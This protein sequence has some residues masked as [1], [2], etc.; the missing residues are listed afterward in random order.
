MIDPN[1]HGSI[2]DL[3]LK[4]CQNVIRTNNT[5]AFRTFKYVRH[6]DRAAYERDGW[7]F[8]AELGPTHGY[9]SVLMEKIEI[10]DDHT[11]KERH[12]AANTRSD[13]RDTPSG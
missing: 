12:G 7:V 11:E 6:E 8:A 10:T 1:R 4:T 5:P 2:S 3:E 13:A 9:Y